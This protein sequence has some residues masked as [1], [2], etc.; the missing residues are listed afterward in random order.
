M[1]PDAEQRKPKPLEDRVALVTGAAGAIGYGIGRALL[2]N[3]CRLAV[4]DIEGEKL[5]RLVTD[6]DPDRTGTAIGVGLDVTDS[7]S[8]SDAFEA[9][10]S[11]WGPPDIVV[12][13]AG[14]DGTEN[15]T[16]SSA[17]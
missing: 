4:T 6:L 17:T 3:G 2:E 1:I 8:V 11:K 15:S 10:A 7:V 14:I 12:H 16:C 9:I 5:E 13:C